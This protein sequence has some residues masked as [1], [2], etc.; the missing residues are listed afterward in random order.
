M[1]RE[2]YL[3]K[4]PTCLPFSPRRKK[5]KIIIIKDNTFV[6]HRVRDGKGERRWIRYMRVA[7]D[8]GAASL[9]SQPRIHGRP[10][11]RHS[12][13]SIHRFWNRY[14]MFFSLSA[15]IRG[16]RWNAKRIKRSIDRKMI[17][18]KRITNRL[19][20]CIHIYIY[21]YKASLL[22]GKQATSL[23]GEINFN[24]ITLFTVDNYTRE[25]D[26]SPAFPPGQIQSSKVEPSLSLR[27]NPMDRKTRHGPH[28]ILWT[29]PRSNFIAKRRQELFGQFRMVVLDRRSE[30]KR[31]F[32]KEI[33]LRFLFDIFI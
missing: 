27:Y 10:T 3:K 19:R 13:P 25:I 32:R 2:N 31:E 24:R 17:P 8:K 20:T 21:I 5:K 4:F 7:L 30:V 14:D 16:F 29:A 23:Q 1:T 26:W 22:F 11:R 28:V 6:N 9:I 12:V 33:R 15:R 18:E